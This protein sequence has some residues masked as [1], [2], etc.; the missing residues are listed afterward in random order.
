MHSLARNIAQRLIDQTLAIDAA[1]ANKGR[2]FDLDS[3]MALTR[4]VMPG[5][6][7][8]MITVIDDSEVY[9]GEGGLKPR[10]DLGGDGSFAHGFP[11]STELGMAKRWNAKNSTA[12]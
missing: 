8:V 7:M 5:M 6:S 11:F 1:D 2:A 10:F 3:E 12:G 9:R 4:S